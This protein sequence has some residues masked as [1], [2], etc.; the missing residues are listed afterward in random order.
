MTAGGALLRRPAG[1]KIAEYI[2]RPDKGYD[3]AQTR[4]R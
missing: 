2:Q 1:V 3:A 4:S